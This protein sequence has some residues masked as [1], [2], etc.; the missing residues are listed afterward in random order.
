MA[1]DSMQS[2][3]DDDILLDKERDAGGEND[4]IVN[5]EKDAVAE[6]QFSEPPMQDS[7]S[8][9]E[10]ADSALGWQ[11]GAGAAITDDDITDENIGGIGMHIEEFAADTNDDD[12]EDLD[13]F[14]V[15]QDEEEHV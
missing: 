13:A 7:G 14:D 12:L 9:D 1:D 8:T 11:K 2:S 15:D 6:E 3:G 10:E 5:S 4:P